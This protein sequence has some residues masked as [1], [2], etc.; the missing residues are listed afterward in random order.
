M[1]AD[2][3]CVDGPAVVS[4]AVPTV[5]DDVVDGVVCANSMSLLCACALQTAALAIIARNEI[6]PIFERRTLASFNR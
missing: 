6:E 3:V 5:P 2:G 4:G 1:V